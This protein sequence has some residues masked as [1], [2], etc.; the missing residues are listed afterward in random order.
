MVPIVLAL[1]IVGPAVYSVTEYVAFR[2]APPYGR[3]KQ[4][5]AKVR[6]LAGVGMSL[7]AV[8]GALVWGL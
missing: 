5:A 4:R 6:M 1:A 3:R 2:R 8:V 7:V